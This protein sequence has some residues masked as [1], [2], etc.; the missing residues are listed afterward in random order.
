M[1]LQAKSVAPVLRFR[2]TS[3]K[4]VVERVLLTLL[5]FFR[6]QWVQPAFETEYL[7]LLAHDLKYLDADQYTKLIDT[8]IHVKRMLINLQKNVRANSG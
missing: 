2:Q 6:Y 5:G 8:V 1:D 4:V 3:P 7:I